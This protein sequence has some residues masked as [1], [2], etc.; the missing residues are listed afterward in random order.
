MRLAVAAA[1]TLATVPAAHA[2]PA[3][4]DAPIGREVDLLIVVDTGPG[5]AG[6]R[7][8]FAQALPGFTTA[9]LADVPDLDLHVGVVT[10]DRADGGVLRTAQ[11]ADCAAAPDRPYVAYVGGV[12]DF[13]GA[14]EDA[15]ACLVPPATATG[16]VDAQPIAVATT[17]LGGAVTADAGFRRPDAALAILFVSAQDDCSHDGDPIDRY[18]CALAGWTCTPILDDGPG[19]RTCTANYGARILDALDLSQVTIEQ[20]APYQ[21]LAI[22]L[23]AG[24]PTHVTEVSGPA[25]APT[26]TDGDL[27][28]GPAVRLAGFVQYFFNAWRTSACAPI[29]LAGFAERIATASEPPVS[30]DDVHLDCDGGYGPPSLG[31]DDSRGCAGCA[32]DA[33]AGGTALAFA[34]AALAWFRRTSPSRRCRARRARAAG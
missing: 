5:S 7:A 17:A 2:A 12:A 18:Q 8:R 25:I 16:G 15:I 21:R 1:L 28:V 31:N 4:P 19:D 29:D 22:G 20:L 13:H 14:L 30:G 24:D 32:S 33:P 11:V 23:V 34:I 26:C 6:L 3:A 10:S 27:V 9:L